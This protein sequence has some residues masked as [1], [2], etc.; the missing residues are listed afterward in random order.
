V[1]VAEIE[2]VLLSISGV[3]EAAVVAR[4]DT[5]GEKHLI[6]YVVP[7]GQLSPRSG[8]LRAVL[9]QK[10]PDLMIPPAFVMLDALP[11]LPSGQVDRRLLPEPRPDSTEPHRQFVAPRTAL[12]ATFAALFSVVL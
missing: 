3:K 6:A 8:M 7:A 5:S 1:E 12:E 10:L 4:K 9:R 11:L 2:Q